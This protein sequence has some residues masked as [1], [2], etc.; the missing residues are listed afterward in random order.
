[1]LI[2]HVEEQMHSRG[3]EIDT[4]DV[5]SIVEPALNDLE[6][7]SSSIWLFTFISSCEGGSECIIEINASFL[8]H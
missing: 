4:S 8:S 2:L 5:S 7:F 1:M 3:R 6:S